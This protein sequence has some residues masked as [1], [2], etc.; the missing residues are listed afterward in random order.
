MWLFVTSR[1]I[2]NAYLVIHSDVLKNIFELIC[3]FTMLSC[4][5]LYESGEMISNLTE[6]EELVINVCLNAMNQLLQ[7]VFFHL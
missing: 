5:H 7:I 4:I 1:I 3:L 2:H 6:T